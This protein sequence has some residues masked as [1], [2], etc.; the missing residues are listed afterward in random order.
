M[1]V[2]MQARADAARALEGYMNCE[3]DNDALDDILLVGAKTDTACYELRWAMID[4]LYCLTYRHKNEG[5]CELTARHQRMFRR[6]TLFLRTTDEWPIPSRFGSSRIWR[7]VMGVTRCLR[8]FITGTSPFS[9]EYWPFKAS[10]D[11]RRF[12]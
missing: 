6:W 5:K 4:T 1:A 2:D 11:W 7:L 12:E 10:D 8:D 9:N 3:I